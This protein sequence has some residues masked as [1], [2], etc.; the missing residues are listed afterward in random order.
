MHAPM[1]TPRP[2]Q[3]TSAL[4]RS[5]WQVLERGLKGH[6][7]RCGGARLF[8]TWL[9]PE[10]SCSA[11][12]LDL[13][14]QQADDFPAYIAILLSGHLLVPVII[15]LVRD[16]TLDPWALAAILLPLTTA[17]I[18]ALLQPAKGAVIATQWWN[19]MH[20]FVRERMPETD[21]QAL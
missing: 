18:L 21:E 4:P 5:Y 1:S 9:K 7:P 14:P 16:Y 12:G 3:P 15:L 10:A 11:C 6:C 8:G 20:G 17:L 2:I 13:R 19:G